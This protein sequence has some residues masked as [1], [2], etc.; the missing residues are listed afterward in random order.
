MTRREPYAVL[1]LKPGASASAIK[2]AWRR[3]AREHH[4]DVS[5]RDPAAA[6][7]ATRRMAE[8]N[9]AYEQLRQG[10]LRS[11]GV[12]TGSAGRRAGGPPPPK[13]TRPVTARLDT[14]DILHPRNATTTRA[15]G[16]RAHP[17]GQPPIRSR[18]AD[19]GPRRASDPNGPLLRSRVRRFRPPARPSLEQARSTEMPFGKFHGHTLGE[20]AAFEP[21]YID[22]MASTISR[23][24]EL[25]S[26]ARVLREDLD[27][28]GIVRRS[29]PI[30]TPPG[31]PTD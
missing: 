21:S 18:A 23:D 12:G 17:G 24:P 1:G 27:Q 3:L 26:A 7:A 22:W 4:P 11:A 19:T 31:P 28:R 14:T 15:D 25:L 2:A 16:R 29:R 30:R 13:P 5:G 6:R 20:I 8:I 9:T 10:P